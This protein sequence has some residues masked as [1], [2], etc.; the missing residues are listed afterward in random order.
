MSLKKQVKAISAIDDD[1]LVVELNKFFED[2]GVR[3]HL[4]AVTN[5]SGYRT[6]WLE[7]DNED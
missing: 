3:W 1:R 2:A 5:G 7:Y 4:V 6:A